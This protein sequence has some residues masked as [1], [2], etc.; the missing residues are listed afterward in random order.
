MILDG[1][2]IVENSSKRAGG[3]IYYNEN[4][5]HLMPPTLTNN[6]IRDNVGKQLDVGS[7]GA[8]IEYNNIEGGFAGKGNIDKEPLLEDDRFELKASA[9]TYDAN[10]C[11]TIF[12]C[13]GKS[14]DGGSLTGRVVRVGRKWS[15]V[16]S[17]GLQELVVWGKMSGEGLDLEIL[18]GYYLCRPP[19]GLTGAAK[20]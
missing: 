17:G 11:V 6:T 8:R 3:V 18:P 20:P 5:P 9:A 2:T 19:V 15:M 1:N 10:R 14:F 16:K 7:E 12:S 4:W 13:A